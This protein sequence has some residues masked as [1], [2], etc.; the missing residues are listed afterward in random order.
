MVTIS[1]YLRDDVENAL[2]VLIELMTLL[3]EFRDDIVL[4]GGWIPYF[5]LDKNKDEHIGSLDI[6]LALNFKRISNNT[7]QTILELLEKRGYKPG[8]QPFIFYRE[9]KTKSNELRTVQIDLLSGEY[10]GTGG[11]HR[12]QKI[13]DIRARKARG[14]DLSFDNYVSISLSGK[15][16][17]GAR[18]EITIKIAG[19]VPFI[20][21]K[22][23]ALWDRYKEKDA[24]DIYFSVLNYPGGAQRLAAK[25]SP[26]ITNKLVLEG[27]GKIR[28]K[29]K[30]IN[31]PGPVWVVNFH[32]IDDTEERERVQRDVFER[33][34]AFLDILEIE[35]Y[36]V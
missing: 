35:S 24:Y 7:Y 18:N 32:E 15:M 9:I 29:F 36:D 6:D 13:Q 23:M 31:S 16:P 14:C 12:T 26:F 2:A 19:I 28:T 5:L 27:L 33:M 20:T 22:G 3:G 25:F 10:G 17:D 11:K 1:D 4:I 8:K 21:M 30:D 34:K